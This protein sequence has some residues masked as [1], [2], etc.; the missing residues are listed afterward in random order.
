[1]NF[2]RLLALCV[3]LWV[4]GCAPLQAP[5]AKVSAELPAQW[6]APLPHNG[7]L[8][9]LNQW[10]QSLGD[11]LLVEL[12]EAAQV[13]SPSMATATSRIAQARATQVG[14]QATLGPTLDA[15]LSASRGVTQPG[16]PAAS[17]GQGSFQAAWEIDLL[18]GN[19]AASNAAREREAGAQALWHEARVSVAAEVANQYIGHRSCHVQLALSRQDATSRAETARLSGLTTR[20]GFTAPAQDAL[21]RASAAEAANRVTQQVALCDLTVKGL[22]ALT[23]LPETELRQKLAPANYKPV[24]DVQFSV[25]QV[26]AQALAQRPDVYSA[27]RDLAA[28]SFDVSS[29]DAQRYP[30]LALNG[31]IGAMSYSAAGVSSDFTTWSIGP[32]ALSLPLFDGGR[33]A[34]NVQAAKARY[35]EAAALYRAR[36]RLAVREVEEALVNLQSTTARNADTQVAA[37]GYRAAFKATQARYGS[38]LASLPELED[39]RRTALNADIGVL[40]LQRERQLAWV[41]LY[42]AA[43]GGWQAP[44]ANNNSAP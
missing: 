18:G 42:R 5:P 32:V 44:T 39:A 34:A 40:S 30:H 29:R 25:A 15:S 27:E 21:A 1:M 9:D 8:T 11:P 23:A 37:E 4:I 22:V 14:S 24:Q 33:R 3:P 7:Q 43:G 38:G 31:S 10:W 20:A 28:A 16:V 17:M 12:I 35:D 2:V 13:A 19:R 41:A 36:V 26:P 6:Q